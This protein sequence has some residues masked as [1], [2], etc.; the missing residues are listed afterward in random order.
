MGSHQAL[1]DFATGPVSRGLDKTNCIVLGERRDINTTGKKKRQPSSCRMA[2]VPGECHGYYARCECLGRILLGNGHLSPWGINQ[3]F[4]GAN[5]H[6]RE[7]H[8]EMPGSRFSN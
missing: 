4:D 6:V 7:V 2:G 3:F 8:A 1:T 5:T